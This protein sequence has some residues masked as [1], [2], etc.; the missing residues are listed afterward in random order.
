MNDS[1]VSNSIVKLDA[2]LLPDPE[3]VQLPAEAGVKVVVTFHGVDT[4]VK[5]V[6]P[7]I[8]IVL[9]DWV[10]LPVPPEPWFVTEKSLKVLSIS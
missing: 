10:T 8:A 4:V 9:A 6:A 3:A 1:A 5:L 7:V 2:V